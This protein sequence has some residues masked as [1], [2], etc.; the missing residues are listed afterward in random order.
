VVDRR[1]AL[2]ASGYAGTTRR[3]GA[4]RRARQFKK[5]LVGKQPAS[6]SRRAASSTLDGRRCAPRPPTRSTGCATWDAPLRLRRLRHA[7]GAA[8][9]RAG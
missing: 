9:G 2:D 5:G 1:M 4:R 3:R 7:G 8:R 6:W